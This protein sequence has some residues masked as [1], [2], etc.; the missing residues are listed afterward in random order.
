MHPDEEIGNEMAPLGLEIMLSPTGDA[1]SGFHTQ[2]DP[3]APYQRQNIIE[4]KTAV[5]IR[6]SFVDIVHGLLTP[7]SQEFSTLLV[8]QFRFDPRKRARR[9]TQVDIEL[10]FASCDSSYPDPEV[11]AIAPNERLTLSPTTQTV[12][13]L[14]GGEAAIG[15]GSFL[16]IGG[17]ARY[18]RSVSHEITHACM[19][20]GSIDLRGRNYGKANCASWTLIENPA[21]KEGVPAS[22]QTAILLRRRHEE[23]FQGHMT[24]KARADW[25]TEL[26]W[27]VG[28]TNRDDPILFDP[29][30]EPTSS[31]HQ[32]LETGMADIDLK[33]LVSIQL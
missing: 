19:V 24:V 27:L 16:T 33:A 4:R 3:A 23:V 11:L 21:S 25:R 7:D 14:V 8:L 10:R 12:T 6:C 13:T 15:A 18:E 9:V 1:G 17:A 5:D 29:I 26:E 2:N 28:R 30:L 31:R 22:M 32:E 20:A